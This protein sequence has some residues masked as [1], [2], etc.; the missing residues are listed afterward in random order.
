MLKSSTFLNTIKIFVKSDTFVKVGIF[1]KVCIFVKTRHSYEKLHFS[2]HLKNT[3]CQ[4]TT[5]SERERKGGADDKS[6][7]ILR[8]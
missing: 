7:K 6:D 4:L 1:L 5:M 8:K 2:F 3:L